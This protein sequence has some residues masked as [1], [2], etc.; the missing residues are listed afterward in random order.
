MHKGTAAAVANLTRAPPIV[1]RLPGP[2]ARS[3]RLRMQRCT[4]FQGGT[5]ERSKPG[6]AIPGAVRDIAFFTRQGAAWR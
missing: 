3:D 6:S 1:K 4:R 2:C 5:S